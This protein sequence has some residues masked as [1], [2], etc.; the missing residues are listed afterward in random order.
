MISEQI[1]CSS[2]PFGDIGALIFHRNCLRSLNLG[3]RV[4]LP[5]FTT[6]PDL[7]T[8]LKLYA[9]L[10][11]TH[12]DET[13]SFFVYNDTSPAVRKEKNSESKISSLYSEY[14]GITH[15]YF[16][17]AFKLKALSEQLSQEQK[18]FM[19]N[20]INNHT[21]NLLGYSNSSEINLNQENQTPQYMYMAHKSLHSKICE[22]S[23]RIIE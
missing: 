9:I 21:R 14:E 20:T 11:G 15:I 5:A 7:D 17:T 13:I 10:C 6:F 16:L 12:L 18:Q 19:L 1:A 4:A 8:Y 22:I 23:L 3:V 2:N